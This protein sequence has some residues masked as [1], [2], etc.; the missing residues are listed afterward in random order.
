MCTSKKSRLAELTCF[1]ELLCF[2]AL[3]PLLRDV[4]RL[5]LPLVDADVE[6]E[7]EAVGG[8]LAAAVAA[9]RQR[10]LPRRPLLQLAAAAALALRHLVSRGLALIE[11]KWL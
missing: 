7:V 8:E 11:R 5:R 3:D 4:E 10:R 2:C 1:E 9:R 6:V